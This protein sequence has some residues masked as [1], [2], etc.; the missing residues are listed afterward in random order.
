MFAACLQDERL[1]PPCGAD[2]SRTP[3]TGLVIVG[4]K[5]TRAKGQRMAAARATAER[6]S[7]SRIDW[8]VDAAG[9]ALKELAANAAAATAYAQLPDGA[10]GAVGWFPQQNLLQPGV[11]VRRVTKAQ[12]DHGGLL[13]STKAPCWRVERNLPPKN[14]QDEDQSG[15][16]YVETRVLKFIDN[17]AGEVD[18]CT[19]LARAREFHAASALMDPSD[20]F[21]VFLVQDADAKD[22]RKKARC[23]EIRGG[24][25]NPVGALADQVFMELPPD[26]PALDSDD[27]SD[28]VSMLTE[29]VSSMQLNSNVRRLVYNLDSRMRDAEAQLKALSATSSS[30]SSSAAAA[31]GPASA[32]AEALGP[33]FRVPR[34]FAYK[35]HIYREVAP[36]VVQLKRGATWNQPHNV[37]P[38][39]AAKM[40]KWRDTGK[41]EQWESTRLRGGGSSGLAAAAASS[42]S[43]FAS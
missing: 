36:G 24:A 22:A 42:S 8:N 35:N 7:T 15:F 1:A 23:A 31:A 39:T 14:L 30:S 37:E 19:I 32:L 6:A 20:H 10:R 16:F 34:E 43:A 41:Q 26:D 38:F 2:E 27:E 40:I 13:P 3:Q 18:K 28:S 25:M 4:N 29:S 12:C 33:P 11:Y 9:N 5:T 17:D 21:H